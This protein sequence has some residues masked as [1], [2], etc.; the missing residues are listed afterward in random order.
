MNPCLIQAAL[1][2]DSTRPRHCA[3]KAYP[4]PSVTLQANVVFE[5]FE[6][7]NGKFHILT[8]NVYRWV[9]ELNEH[10]QAH[11]LCC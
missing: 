2:T 1:I 9:T 7:R 11:A 4:V 8:T 3:A 10:I 6:T 5:D